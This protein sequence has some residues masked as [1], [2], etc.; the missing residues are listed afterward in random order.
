M[1]LLLLFGLALAYDPQQEQLF[2][3]LTG[4]GSGVHPFV[5]LHDGAIANEIAFTTQ[6]LTHVYLDFHKLGNTPHTVYNVM[7]HELAHTRGAVHGDGSKEMNYAVTLD[8]M[9]RVVDD[10][11][12]L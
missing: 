11:Y 1:Y 2:R 9:G 4:P 3:A 7:R 5:T 6:D 8:A 10:A 12:F